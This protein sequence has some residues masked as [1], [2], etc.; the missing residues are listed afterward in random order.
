MNKEDCYSIG[1]ISKTHG[2]KGE[3]TVV[4]TEAIDLESLGA[5]FIEVKNSLVPY[6]IQSF[7]ERPDKAFIKFEEVDTP[8]KAN[9]IKGCAIYV[10]K[11]TRPALK[12]G[13]FYNDEV[14]GFSIEDEALGALGIVTEVL[15][16]GPTRLLQFHYQE[17]KEVLIPVNAPFITSVNKSKKLIKVSLP[18]GFLDI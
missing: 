18:D 11:T 9:M 5:V 3:V 6:F 14:I 1:Y 2:L 13:H 12:R 17:K 16:S 15:Q 7:S 4:F 8:E 10:P